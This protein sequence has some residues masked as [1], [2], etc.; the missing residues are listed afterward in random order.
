MRNDFL[1]PLKMPCSLH[2]VLGKKICF[3]Q[4][5]DETKFILMLY[6]FLKFRRSAIST[7]KPAVEN[8]GWRGCFEEESYKEGGEG[9][10]YTR[11]YLC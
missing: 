11:I 8:I 5:Y 10:F 7:S 6:Q 1:G 3:S 4:I 9:I 2:Q